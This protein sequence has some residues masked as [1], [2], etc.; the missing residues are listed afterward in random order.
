MAIQT[1]TEIDFELETK[2]ERWVVGAYVRDC[3]PGARQA[4]QTREQFLGFGEI[5]GVDGLPEPE[6]YQHLLLNFY[7]RQHMAATEQW[8][9]G[10]AVVARQ[11]QIEADWEVAEVY[12]ARSG[13]ED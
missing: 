7:K 12:P 13:F 6:Q 3:S 4:D 11:V 10:A 8:A 1:K 2:P 9:M 5:N